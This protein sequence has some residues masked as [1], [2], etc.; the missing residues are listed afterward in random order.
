MSAVDIGKL[1]VMLEDAE[2]EHEKAKRDYSA[3]FREWDKAI[4]KNDVIMRRC[5]TTLSD[6]RPL[7]LRE[8]AATRDDLWALFHR[9]SIANAVMDLAYDRRRALEDLLER[10]EKAVTS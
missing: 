8:V 9:R 10:A 6:R 7:M 1:R 4:W 2:A 5:E 3:A